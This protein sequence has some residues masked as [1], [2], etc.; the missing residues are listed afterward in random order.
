MQAPNSSTKQRMEFSSDK[1]WYSKY[2]P[3]EFGINSEEEE[4]PGNLKQVTSEE[5]SF[6]FDVPKFVDFVQL[7]KLYE[8]YGTLALREE[9]RLEKSV[10]FIEKFYNHFKNFGKK[11]SEMV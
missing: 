10:F 5:L 7:R 8:S 4:I 11:I 9:E 1:E 6:E 2:P 3:D